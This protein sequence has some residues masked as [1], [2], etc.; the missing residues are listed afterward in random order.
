MHSACRL[1]IIEL[2]QQCQGMNLAQMTRTYEIIIK[3]RRLS[4]KGIARDLRIY[5]GLIVNLMI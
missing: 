5:D 1:V 3:K 2:M 4:C